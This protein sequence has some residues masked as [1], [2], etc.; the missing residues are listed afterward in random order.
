MS[1]P[2]DPAQVV[3]TSRST[4]T[5]P[6][7]CTS[8]TS[9]SARGADGA[10]SDRRRGT[11][12]RPGADEERERRH[13]RVDQ[14]VHRRQPGAV[15][16]ARKTRAAAAEARRVLVGLAS[17]RFKA[18]ASADLTIA[19]GV[20][21][22]ARRRAARG[23]LRRAAGRQ[24]IR[25][26]VRAVPTRA[27]I[28]LPRKGRDHAAP[29][30][31]G[32]VPHRRHSVHSPIS[33]RRSA[34]PTNTFSTSVC[35]ECCTAASS[36][37]AGKGR[38]AFSNPT[39]AA[40]ED[41]SVEGIPGVRIV[42]RRNFVGV[43]AAREWDAVRAARQ[44]KVTWN[45]SARRCRVTR[46]CSELPVRQ[47]RRCGRHRNGRRGRP[48]SLAERT[49]SPPPIRGRISRTGRWRRT[50]RSSTSRATARS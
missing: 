2:P 12:P 34:A 45:R 9:S 36:G 44:L 27:G 5:T 30:A 26:R 40:V 37:R 39:V 6:R 14:G 43:V 21:S 3:G 1:G 49:S 10:A 13:P 22:L 32:R 23:H 46:G 8:A 35:P 31:A 38:T 18:L 47:D 4:R 20:V 33:R 25:S 50:A 24:A 16:A 7:R 19:K 17:K 48:R 41:G 15:W 11:R 28:E 42:R 29:E